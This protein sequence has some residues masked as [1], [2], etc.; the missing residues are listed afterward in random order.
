MNISTKKSK[1]ETEEVFP[2]N[3]H[4]DDDDECVDAFAMVPLKSGDKIL[5]TINFEK[6]TIEITSPPLI[7]TNDSSDLNFNKSFTVTD[8]KKDIIDNRTSKANPNGRTPTVDG[9]AFDMVRSYALRRST[10]RTL[11]KIK[12]IH[13]DDNV[14]L[15]TIVDEAIRAYYETLNKINQ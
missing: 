8:N 10:V 12:A 4:V 2:C 3:D 15:N 11:S 6:E 9:E 1:N 13:K 7:S 14:Y 5:E